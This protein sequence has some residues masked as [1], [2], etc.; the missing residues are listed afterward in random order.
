[1]SGE[2][3]LDSP[4]TRRL[5]FAAF[6]VTTVASTVVC[7]VVKQC[8][9][10]LTFRWAFHNLIALRDLYVLHPGQH[11]DLFKYSPT[12]ALLFAPFTLP[13]FAVAL[14]GWNLLNGLL[15]YYAVARLLPDRRGTL[16]LALLYP[17]FLLSIDGTQSNG[18]VAALIILAFIAIEQRRQLIAALAIAGGALIK[19]FPLAALLLVVPHR[20]RLRFAA[21]FALVC[22]VLVLLPLTVTTPGELLAQYRSWWRL[23]EVDALD[24]G[25]SLMSLLHLGFGY[26]GHNVLVQLAGTALLMAPL[27]RR[28]AWNDPQF[29][30][31]LL[32]SLLIYSVIFNHKAEQPTFVVAIAGVSIW[33]ATSERSRLRDWLVGAALILMIPV[34]VTA[35]IGQS[36]PTIAAMTLPALRLAAVP[37]V[38]SW[39]AIETELFGLAPNDLR[40]RDR[41][42]HVP[43]GML[44]GMEETAHH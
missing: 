27:L 3:M 38:L 25:A 22:V 1:M 41:L 39:F 19:L 12:F 44:G 6:V 31:R 5:I 21:I 42:P 34:F 15:L 7:S 11:D 36:S 29:R 24:R 33:Y 30:L 13:P 16:A 10:F 32:A 4:W 28:G 17:G 8:N 14:L 20:G 2:R 35:M 26:S 37:L 23:E 9:N 40:R 18:L 43:T